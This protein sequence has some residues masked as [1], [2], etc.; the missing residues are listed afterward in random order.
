M[1][2]CSANVPDDGSAGNGLVDGIVAESASSAKL[3]DPAAATAAS[4][5]LVRRKSRRVIDMR[6][7]A[8]EG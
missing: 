5:A 4:E 1:D 2:F 7:F 3:I 6:A 8:F